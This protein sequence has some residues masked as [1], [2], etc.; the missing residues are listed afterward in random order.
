MV[1]SIPVT[2]RVKSIYG[3]RVE[4]CSRCIIIRDIARLMTILIV[5]CHSIV[6][7]ELT[8]EMLLCVGLRLIKLMLRCGDTYLM[9]LLIGILMN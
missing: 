5:L 2:S 3:S 1:Y 7:D 8:L 6:V 9:V 4:G